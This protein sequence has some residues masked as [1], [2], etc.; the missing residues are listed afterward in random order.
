MKTIY[1]EDLLPK[2]YTEVGEPAYTGRGSHSV[3]QLEEITEG[4]KELVH[5]LRIREQTL[6]N[7]LN[8][9][10]VSK[11]TFQYNQLLQWGDLQYFFK[12]EKDG[13]I[14]LANAKTEQHPDYNDW[15]VEACDVYVC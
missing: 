2:H 1:K 13:K 12:E 8:I 7:K 10:I 15:W 11:R 14:L 6:L 4:Y 5:Q 3:A 9:T